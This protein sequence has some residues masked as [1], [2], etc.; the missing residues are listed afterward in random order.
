MTQE[1]NSNHKYW[2]STDDLAGTPEF[3][4][5]SQNEFTDKAFDAEPEN[6]LGRRKFLGVV[7]ASMAVAG[8]TSG[9]FR[10]PKEKILPYAVRPEEIIEGKPL[11]YATSLLAGSTVL[12]VLV[13]SH[14]GRPTKIEG[15]PQ[16]PMSFGA[17]NTWAQAQILDLYDPDRSRHVLNANS[18]STFAALKLA[19]KAQFEADK[20]TGGKGVAL[21]IDATP[22]PTYLSLVKQFAAAFPQAKIY[23][24]DAILQVNRRA[25][26]KNLGHGSALLNYHADKADVVLALDSDFIGFE[27]DSVRNARLF[28]SKRRIKSEDSR[29]NRLYSVEPVLTCTGATADNRLSLRSSQ[30]GEFILILA[31]ELSRLGVKLPAAVEA[32]VK[33]TN[34]ASVSYAKWVSTLSTDLA[35]NRGKSLIIVGE[36]QPEWVHSLAFALNEGLGSLG[37]T[38]SVVSDA[39]A[40]DFETLAQ[41]ADSVKQAQI[42]SVF[43]LGGNPVYTASVDLKIPELLKQIPNSFHLGYYPDETAQ[44]CTWHIPQC[45]SLEAWGDLRASD[46]T[47]GIRQPLIA[48]LFESLSE[49]EFISSLVSGAVVSGYELVRGHWQTKLKSTDFMRDWR[50]ALHDG[51]FTL[52]SATSTAASK[53]DFLGAAISASA[54]QP[55][56]SA[57]SLELRFVYDSHAFDGRY[58]NNAWM[59]ELPDSISKL[60]W[61]NAALMSPK[62]ALALGV[63]SGKMIELTYQGAKLNIAAF[64][65]PGVAEFTVVLP[66]GYGRQFG[67]VA[68]G[69]GFNV[70]IVRQSATPWFGVGAKIVVGTEIYALASTQEHGSMENRPIVREATLAE[71][72][73]DPE[74]AE[75]M[76]MVEKSKQKTF[77]WDRPN[78][79]SGQQWGMTI[80]LS[81]C[82]GCNACTIACQAENNISVVGKKQVLN[83]REMHWIRIDR[84]FNGSVDDP[85]S[86]FQPLNCMQCENAPC[87][88]VCPVGATVHSPE[89]LNDMAYNRCI[90]TRYC[91][92]NCPYKVRRFN[93]HNYASRNDDANPL[94]A[95]QKNP[96]VTVRFRGV[97]EK[98]TY[99]VQ[100]IN[101]SKIE[102]R[103]NGN[104][105]VA[106]GAIVTACQQVCPTEA[107]VFGDI[108][109]P[110][111][112]VAQ[113]KRQNRDYA[114]LAELNTQPRTSYLAKIRNPHPEL[115]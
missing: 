6:G 70:N 31:A 106:D 38:M 49:I 59:Q 82:T 77:L 48:P 84:Y 87:E 115:V 79:I 1:K 93:F 64:V 45:H 37:T 92:N 16:H 24:D 29:M 46:A 80:D 96:N 43:I 89:G 104:G 73:K 63:S 62:T 11:F 7:G 57:D 74:F 35:S 100:R 50:K 39:D 68:K 22:S 55:A 8:L 2:R 60:T 97:M 25:S 69:A 76:E 102:S 4:N 53:Y 5:A 41:F 72:R 101:E 36:S 26:L 19:L 111:S 83:G 14:E 94:Y 40:T 66:L 17:T 90:G 75:K 61:D 44:L 23:Q 58:A 47:C 65:V 114:L 42:Q 91:A 9:C 109:N 13:E 71:Y 110:E 34:A 98:C 10:K 113:M 95:M 99:C 27:G 12:G 18:A 107:I 21:V 56:P 51:I 54:A 86:V 78:T 3:V 28:A 81:V 20:K 112:K 33:A 108:N 32:R 52:P 15:N 103:K 85:Q 88:S 105:V 30:M 67:S